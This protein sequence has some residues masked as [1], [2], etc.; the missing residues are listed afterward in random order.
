MSEKRS[1]KSYGVRQWTLK[2]RMRRLRAGV[3]MLLGVKL[4][5][6][7]KLLLRSSKLIKNVATQY[8]LDV[9]LG[10]K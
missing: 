7:L 1:T 8:S 2:S 6:L 9:K 4:V 10:G 3:D 5:K